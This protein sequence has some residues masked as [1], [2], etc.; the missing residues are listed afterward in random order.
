MKTTSSVIA[1]VALLSGVLAIDFSGY[2]PQKGVQAEF[3]PFLNAL[4]TAAEDPAATTEYTDYFTEDGMQTTLSIHCVG[5]AAI[6]RCKNGFL[7][8]NG[9]MK[10]IVQNSLHRAQDYE[11]QVRAAEFDA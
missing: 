10:L 6:T 8:T 9:S 5:A 11:R 2:K 4:V 7:P 1:Y 3:K